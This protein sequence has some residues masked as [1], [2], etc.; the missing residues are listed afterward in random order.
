MKGYKQ[1]IG[2]IAMFD[3][4]GPDIVVYMAPKRLRVRLPSGDIV[5]LDETPHYQYTIGN[6]QPYC[7]WLIE[8]GHLYESSLASFE[9]LM[10]DESFYL[11]GQHAQDFIL[12]DKNFVIIDGVHRATR[13]FQLGARRIP[14]LWRS[15][16]E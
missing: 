7:D 1:E 13:L 15:S 8:Y 3:Y 2:L 14:V 16:H 10:S 6:K 11:E 12:C 9:H 5:A 4:K